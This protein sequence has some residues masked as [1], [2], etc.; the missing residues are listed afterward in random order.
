MSDGE[1]T[2]KIDADTAAYLM[3]MV[4]AGAATKKNLH[5]TVKEAHGPMKEFG[6]LTKDA[7][8]ILLGWTAPIGFA[9]SAMG[10]LERATD[11]WRERLKE[12]SA[13]LDK[14][15]SLSQA[16]YA[17]GRGG[18]VRAIQEQL[19][20]N[21]PGLDEAQKKS[22][23]SSYIQGNAIASTEDVGR[24]AGSAEKASLLG[25]D[26]GQFSRIQGSLDRA[27][28]QHSEDVANYLMQ[29]APDNADKAAA[30][31]AKAPSQADDIAQLFATGERGGRGSRAMLLKVEADWAMRGSRGSIRD[32][33]NP[34]VA[35]REGMIDMKFLADP[36]NQAPAVQAGMLEQDAAAS[37][38]NP[39]LRVQYEERLTQVSAEQRNFREVSSEVRRRRLATAAESAQDAR[40]GWIGNVLRDADLATFDGEVSYSR[41]KRDLS[42]PELLAYLKNI[43][44]SN[45]RLATPPPLRPRTGQHGEHSP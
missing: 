6:E 24:A 25:R 37:L 8:Q 11:A 39:E 20:R 31:I 12:G 18:E 14:I 43:R 28:V 15:G 27:G 2:L 38:E 3:K 19:D 36:H 33:I 26:L 17:T 44:D 32:S 29:Y 45:A 4:E 9:A 1:V 10:V 21:A 41:L 22:V 16:I 42:E 23:F 5:D 40:H 30:A 34:R 35:G 13:Y 7:A